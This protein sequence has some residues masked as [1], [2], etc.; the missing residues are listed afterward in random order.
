MREATHSMDTNSRASLKCGWTIALLLGLAWTPAF[1]Q[2]NGSL[3][4]AARQARAQKQGQGQADAGQAQ[5]VADEL[6][7]DQNDSAPGGFK[8]Y[9]AGDYRIWVPAPYTLAGRDASGPVLSGPTVGS[10]RS[11]VLLANTL[12]LPSA[13]G[14]EAFHDAAAQFART[15][16]QTANCSQNPSAGHNTYQCG[17]A[18]ANLLGQT[19]SGNVWFVRTGA[20]IY[21]VFC[22]APTDSRNRDILNDAHS[23][24]SQKEYA[25][26][27][28]ARE[29][30]DL[31]DVWQKCDIAFQSIRIKEHASQ[32][33]ASQTKAEQPSGA[34]G[35][36]AAIPLSLSNQAGSTVPTGLKVQAFQYCTGVHQCWDASVL[37]P[38]EAR[39][40][41]SQCKQYAFEITVSGSPFLL[42]AGP[43]GSDCDAQG[44]NPADQVRWHQ[45]VDPEIKRAPGTYTT[46][47]AQTRKIDGKPASVITLVFRKGLTDWMGKRAE[48]D[49]NGTQVVVG[50]MGLRDHFA[51]AETTCSA[52]IESLRLP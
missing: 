47:S 49:T 11:L 32:N 46:I 33:V 15:F 2:Q 39:L 1:G 28:L 3:A 50:C 26:K 40:V 18:A 10:K 31:K 41:S 48:V 27:A 16:S 9:N 30:Q 45:L 42:M 20:S 12:L 13:A 44:S 19:V 14:E 29:D 4:D 8:T 34:P 17:L 21:P 25:R 6:S 52:L 22:A 36:P 51:D 24:Y 23:S 35:A 5:Q 37:V 43:A 38:A 7:E